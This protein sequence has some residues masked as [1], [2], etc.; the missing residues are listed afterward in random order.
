[1][2]TIVL[3]FLC[4]FHFLKKKSRVGIQNPCSTRDLPVTTHAFGTETLGFGRET[5]GLGETLGF[6]KPVTKP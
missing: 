5:P 6:T 1:M 4:F 3:H 2:V